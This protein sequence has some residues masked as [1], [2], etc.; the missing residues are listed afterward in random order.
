MIER[1]A[2]GVCPICNGSEWVC[3]NH[4][5][6]EWAG[7]SGKEECCGGAGMPCRLCNHEM[8]CAGLSHQ[9]AKAEREAIVAWL[10]KEAKDHLESGYEE[11]FMVYA[12]FTYAVNAI[13]AGQHLENKDATDV[14]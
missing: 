6:I 12:A 7:L 5:H 13:L 8:S 9:A 4:P 14:I 11:V 10:R 3:E 2:I 1:E